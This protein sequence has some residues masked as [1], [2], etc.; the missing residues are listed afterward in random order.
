M[1]SLG[2]HICKKKD[3]ISRNIY[4]IWKQSFT[5]APFPVRV[6]YGLGSIIAPE[7]V[8][9]MVEEGR[10]RGK[11]SEL[12]EINNELESLQL[13]LTLE[14]NQ[15]LNDKDSSQELNLSKPEVDT[16]LKEIDDISKTRA[17]A[18]KEKVEAYKELTQFQ[19][20]AMNPKDNSKNKIYHYTTFDTD[21]PSPIN[22]NQSK[23]DY[24]D[25]GNDSIEVNAH[26]F[27]M[28]IGDQDAISHIH[29]VIEAVQGSTKKFGSAMR[30]ALTNATHKGM[31]NTMEN[32]NVESTL[33]LT[34]TAFHRY[35][36]QFN[37][38]ILDPDQLYDC[39]NQMFPH[40][41]INMALTGNRAEREAKGSKNKLS[42]ISEEFLGSALVGMVHF[43]KKEDTE[44][45]QSDS[46]SAMKTDLSLKQSSAFG[47][48]T[49]DTGVATQ[50]ASKAANTLSQTGID[51][52]FDLYC[53]GYLPKLES[54]KITD[55]IKE[56]SAFSP[57]KFNVAK[58]K[59]MY[60]NM[61]KEQNYLIADNKQNSLKQSYS[62]AMIQATIM[63]LSKAYE[64]TYQ[65]LDYRT[66]MNAFD[67]YVKNVSKTKQCG[68]CSGMDVKHWSKLE[69]RVLI[70]RKWSPDTEN[71]TGYGSTQLKA[72]KAAKRSSSS[73]T[74]T[75]MGDDESQGDDEG[76]DD[77]GGDDQGDDDQGGGD[78]GGDDQGGDDEGGDDQGGD[79][80]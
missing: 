64:N 77:Q 51:V 62:G 31:T 61:N 73:S 11:I 9:S 54:Q 36:K 71:V 41:T 75:G 42:M 72:G 12:E 5:V 74:Q 10:I 49:G 6:G 56:F 4:S 78:Q 18:I 21:M 16:L 65:V 39:W 80:Q 23:I 34:A 7:V 30:S 69:V 19:K 8:E 48:I 15:I 25:R 17:D 37:P 40:D 66:F 68:I 53:E 33:L 22:W 3:H 43:I 28:N 13:D 27:D 67:D 63:G 2:R 76:G 79:D 1:L 59:Y 24:L 46:A 50:V 52:K 38:L 32:H 57:D 60:P 58:E 45:L 44:S 55:A 29:N 20:D 35:V 70:E 14:K 26:F 47:G